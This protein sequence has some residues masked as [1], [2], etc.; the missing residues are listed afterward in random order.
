[1]CFARWLILDC[2]KKGWDTVTEL[3]HSVARQS[4]LRRRSWRLRRT[5]ERSTGGVSAYSSLRCSS[6]R[7]SSFDYVQSQYHVV[8]YIQTATPSGRINLTIPMCFTGF[9]CASKKITGKG[10]WN[11]MILLALAIGCSSFCLLSL[12]VA[13]EHAGM[14]WAKTFFEVLRIENIY[15]VNFYPNK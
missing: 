8:Y 13:R 7:W 1:L 12:M 10:S 15:V 5:P 11:Y 14:D 9:M 2:A 4:S 3:V 6:E